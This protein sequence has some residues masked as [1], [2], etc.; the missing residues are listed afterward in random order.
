MTR[1]LINS[2]MAY[3]SATDTQVVPW[4]GRG[5]NH[6]LGHDLISYRPVIK[7]VAA[8]DLA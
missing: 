7:N 2:G 4:H 8:L 6:L 5:G 1:P 3:M